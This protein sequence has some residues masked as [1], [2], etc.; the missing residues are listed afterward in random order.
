MS[1]SERSPEEVLQ[2]AGG[3]EYPAFTQDLLAT[4]RVQ[5]APEDVVEQ[6]RTLGPEQFAGPGAV[7]AALRHLQEA[8]RAGHAEEWRPPR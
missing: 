3:V 6:L 2:Y 7:L 1:F 4:A 8:G 5:G